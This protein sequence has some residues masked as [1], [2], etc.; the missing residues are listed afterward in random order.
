MLNNLIDSTDFLPT[1][2]EAAGVEVPGDLTVDGRSFLPQLRGEEGDP[3]NWIYCWYARGGGPKPDFEFAM[4]GS[5]KLYRDGRFFDL[6]KG[7]RRAASHSGRRTDDPRKQGPCGLARSARASTQTL[8]RR[9]SR[10]NRNHP[11]AATA[12]LETADE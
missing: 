7:S 3:R 5:Y 8:V 9:T 2:C 12:V 11:R 6:E 10:R 4:N 1:I